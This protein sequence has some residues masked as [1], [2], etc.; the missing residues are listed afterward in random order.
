MCVYMSVHLC[1]YIFVSMDVLV[2]TFICI[3]VI[4]LIVCLVNILVATSWFDIA[5]WVV[6]TFKFQNLNTT[7]CTKTS[8][9]T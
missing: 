3:K 4:Y 1:A 9:S 2:D 5:I 6:F 7:I 8:K